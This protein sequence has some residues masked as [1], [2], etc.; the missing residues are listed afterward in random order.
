VED[1]K[2]TI[3]FH[4]NDMPIGVFKKFKD[5]AKTY[6]DNY[7]LSIQILME[8]EEMLQYLMQEERDEVEYEEPKVNEVPTLGDD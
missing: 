2:A 3:S 1:G 6:R 4:V 5:Y 8:K 7:S